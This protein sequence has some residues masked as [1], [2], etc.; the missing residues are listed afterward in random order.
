MHLSFRFFAVGDMFATICK[1]VGYKE[2]YCTKTHRSGDTC[3]FSHS[4]AGNLTHS[5]FFQSRI[6]CGLAGVAGSSSSVWD[7]PNFFILYRSASR[8]MFSSFAA[9]I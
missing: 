2:G 4:L 1:Q 6:Y 9:L 3:E 8:L 7:R 5:N